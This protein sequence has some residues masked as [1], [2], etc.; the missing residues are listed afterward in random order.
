MSTYKLYTTNL[1]PLHPARRVPQVSPSP[2]AW[3]NRRSRRAW[4]TLRRSA[5]KRLAAVNDPRRLPAGLA[6]ELE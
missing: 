4:K 2:G 5:S 6:V 1:P 3:L